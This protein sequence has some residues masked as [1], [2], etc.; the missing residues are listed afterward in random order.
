MEGITLLIA[1]AALIIAILAYQR[2]GGTA[3]LKRHL[4]STS[5]SLD[6][7][8]QVDSLAAMTDAVREKTADALDRLEK[9]VRKTEK[10]E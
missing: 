10:G 6:L 1:V 7:K 3:D 8:K 9:V 5:S 4:E 2:T